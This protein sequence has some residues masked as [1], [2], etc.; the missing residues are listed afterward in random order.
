MKRMW[1]ALALCAIL[2][3]VCALGI[4]N[5]QK[6]T[7]QMIQT[8]ADA[9]KARAAGDADAALRLSRQAAKSWRGAH[10]VL[11]IYMVHSRL[12][13]IDQTLSGL[14]EL[15]GNESKEQFLSDCDKGLAQLSYLTESE[16]PNL[17]NIF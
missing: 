15:C 13:E 1:A 10:R 9:K 14:P 8:V 3:T 12:E 4:T 16:I 7:V 5:T 11:C 6:V 2:V 17:E